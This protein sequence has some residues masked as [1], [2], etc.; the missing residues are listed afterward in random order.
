MSQ[1]VNWKK[2]LDDLLL[3]AKTPEEAAATRAFANAIAPYL[4]NTELLRTVIGKIQA[5]LNVNSVRVIAEKPKFDSI[6]QLKA[7]LPSD[8]EVIDIR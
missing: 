2:E 3:T 7:R 8:I 4:E 6:D 1:P 5:A